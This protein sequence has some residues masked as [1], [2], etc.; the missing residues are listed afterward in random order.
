[1]RIG[2]LTREFPPEVYGGAGVHVEYLS[3]Q[4][5]HLADVEVHCFGQDRPGAHAY[6][7]PAELT[8]ANF[9]LQTLG[10]DLAMAG[11]VEHCDLVHSHTWYANMAGHWAKLLHGIPHVATTHS[12]EPLRPWKAEQH[13]GG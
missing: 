8:D 1:V 5:R 10:T 3:A 12:L 11:G 7:A 13:G 6:R 2:V 4:L 9:A